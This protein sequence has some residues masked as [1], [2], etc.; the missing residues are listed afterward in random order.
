MHTPTLHRRLFP[1]Y[2]LVTVLLLLQTT[3]QAQTPVALPGNYDP[4]KKVNYV[5]AWDAMAPTQ[6]LSTLKSKPL[7]DVKQTTAYADGLGRPLQTVVKQG[8][9]ATGSSPADLV[10]AVTYDGFGRARYQYLPFAANN[11]GSNTSINDGLFKLNPFPQQAQFY[12][13]QLA[14]QGNESNVATVNGNSLN[15][16]YGQTNYEASALNRVQETFAPGS[17]WVG[18]NGQ[19]LENNR[20]S[21]KNKYLVNTLTDSVRRW[22][23]TEAANDYGSYSTSTRYAAGDLYKH[24]TVDE[25]GKQVVEFTDKAGLTVL[26]KVQLTAAADAGAGSGHEGW[27]CTYYV[28]DNRGLLRLVIQ[29]KAVI[30]LN[31]NGWNIA[32]YSGDLLNELCF[33][34]AYD[35]RSRMSRKKVPGAGEAR[36]VYDQWDRLV[37]S[38]DSTMRAGHQWL[39][40]K[41][42]ALNRPV[43]TGFYTNGSYTTQAAMQG[44]LDAQNLA[45]YEQYQTGSFPQYSLSQSFPV[46]A[47]ADVL[48]VTYYDQ[49]DWASAFGSGYGTKDNSFD[50]VCFTPDNNNYPYAQPLTATT[51][52]RGLVTGTWVKVPGTAQGLVTA[53]FYD[54]KGQVIHTLKNNITANSNHVRDMTTNQYDFSGKLLRTVYRQYKGDSAFHE[55]YTMTTYE[56]DDLNRPVVVRNYVDAYTTNGQAFSADRV[57]VR[58]AYDK[59]GQLTKKV[60]GNRV[61]SLEYEYN[62]RGWSLGVNRS[63]LFAPWSNNHWFGY[64]LAYDKPSNCRAY[65]LWFWQPQFTGNI[66]GTMWRSKGDGMPRK[67]DYTYDAANRLTGADFNQQNGLGW[68]KSAGLDFSVRNLGYDANGNILRMDQQGWK[69]G[70]STTIDSLLY[71]YTNN[72]LSNRLQNVWDRVNDPQTKL[73]DFRSSTTYVAALGS[74]T[75]AAVD[76]TYDGNGNLTKDRNKDIGSSSAEDIVYNYLDLPVSITIRNAN[77]S[78]KGS[79]QY[80]Y[81]AAGNKLRKIVQESGKPDKTTLYLDGFVYENNILQFLPQEEG[82]VRYAKRHWQNGDSAYRLEYDYFMK[83][84]LGNVRMV[85]TEQQDTTQYLATMEAAYRAREDKLFYK[86]PLTN[87]ARASV[88]GGY[89]TDNTTSPNDSLAR[90][91]GSGNKVGPAL[92]LKVMSGDQV[93]LAVKS[94]YRSSGTAGNN[95]SPVADILS[96]LA[97]G[98]VGTAGESKGALAD[99][100]GGSSPLL[101][102]IN[103]FRTDA[104]ADQPTKPKAYLNWLLLDEQ[105]NYVAASSGAVPVGSADVLNTLGN[106]AI[107]ITKNG[108]LYI[109]VSNET[110]N[111][112]VFFDNLSVVHYTGPMVE[113]TH[114]YPFGLTMAGISSKAMGKLDNKYE[115]NGKEKQEQEFSDGSGLEWYDYGAR[116]YDQQIG[117]FFVQDR[118][119]EKYFDFTPYHYCA[120][121]PIRFIDVNGDSLIVHGKDAA[122]QGYEKIVNDGLGGFYTTKTRET[123]TYYLEATGKEGEMTGQQQ[124]LYNEINGVMNS[125]KDVS[126]NVVMNDVKIDIGSFKDGVIDVG[127]M[128][129]FNSINENKHTGSTREGLLAHELVE[130]NELQNSNV[131]RADLEQIQKA[132]SPMHNNSIVNAEN[133]VNNN[134]RFNFLEGPRIGDKEYTKYFG[135]KGGITIERIQNHAKIMIPQKRFIPLK[136]NPGLKK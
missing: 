128:L 87:Y 69:T 17:S 54:D 80:T 89:P 117:R 136:V 15:W 65:Y 60:L 90:V 110:Q 44:Y 26:K 35:G 55:V 123:G 82:R 34:Y 76:Y 2:G 48:S 108:F 14:D 132:F 73:G 1:G 99:L 129:N 122:I 19:A 112:D 97:A 81:D 4:A 33:R 124:A 91:N 57:I 59:L 49:Y 135:E 101:G 36:M 28:N 63:Y 39:F 70:G 8:S 20:H 58:N 16:A 78:V 95:N 102:A 107:P 21:V 98:I 10:S 22:T 32:S 52:T 85:L 126:I 30:L 67:Y 120:N 74:K 93:A 5:R 118:F 92:V 66:T 133:S 72:G 51:Q 115:Y 27:L 41:Y 23:V 119:A 62:P 104:V 83:D 88:P 31:G 38:Q 116:M 24:I 94:F 121:N 96:S 109:Y 37:L 53:T 11:A 64:E 25:A 43:V 47:A 13:T 12:N 50:V 131:N 56:Y 130:Q 71:T 61:D 134:V 68:D 45:R 113:E 125:G 84:H 105:L 40:T 86:I 29:P 3:A 106:S 79:I 111:W 75:I 42:D 114:Y 77:G 46:A 7:R 103:S 18:S 100:T 6:D 127:D 9:L